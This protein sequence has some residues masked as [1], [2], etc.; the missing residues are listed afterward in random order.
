MTNKELQVVKRTGE[1]VPFN[2]TKI[3]KA[4]ILAMKNGSG[5]YL[6]DIARLISNDAEKF[7]AKQDKS[8]TIAQVEG[9]VYKRLVHYGQDLTARAYEGFRA[10]Q[11]FKREKDPLIESVMGLIDFSN[12]EVMKENANKQATLV[13]TRRDLV[14]G[15]VSKT[16]SR[17]YLI[18]P[19]LVQANDDGIIKIHDLDY[20]MDGIYNCELINLED[21]LQNGTV[22]NKKMIRK[23]KSLRTAMTIATQISAQVSSSTY[24]GQTMTL[25]HLAPFVRISKEK[26]EERFNKSLGN[27]VSQSVI[28]KLVE[29]ELRTEI[30]D[31]VQT[32]NYQINTISCT[33]GQTPFI[34]LAMYIAED[35]EYEKETAM[36]IEEFLHQRI[37][38]MENEYGVKTTQTFPKLLYFLD[39]NNTYEGSEYFYL[40]KLAAESV[41]KRM[42]PD[43]IS[44]KQ[45]EALYGTAYPCMGCRAFLTPWFNE[46]IGKY[47]CYGRGNLGVATVNLPDIALSCDADEE[48]FFE[49]LEKRLDLCKEVG[50]LRYDKL[51]G[52]KAKTA[53]ILWQ[54][55]AIARLEPEDDIIKA[56]DDRKFTVSFGYAGLHEAVLYMTGESLTSEKGQELGKKI[57]K[58]IVDYK[59]KAKAETGLWFAVYGTPSESTAGWFANKMKNRF[60]VVPGITD[61]GRITNSY[62]IDVEEEIDAFSKLEIE[63]EFAKYSLGGTITYV[64]VYNLTKNIEAVVSLVQ[65]MYEN[66]IY[67]EINTESDNC[68]T[69]GYQ[70]VI[71]V[72]EETLKWRCPQC[73]E[74]NQDKL[75]VVRRTCGYLSETNWCTSRM[76]DI[77]NRVKHL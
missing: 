53:P 41:A 51:K 42:A 45:M 8:P 1:L 15:E 37:E 21:M 5:I 68:A 66:N 69:C 36:L 23:P 52:V 64:E 43:F 77:I 10:V 40:T 25:T 13:S 65:F 9:Y 59:D 28:D 12:E 35:S 49:I 61:R 71:E 16:I 3:K 60:G 26:I 57:M 62:H 54:H 74:S 48:M 70:G 56:I 75:S 7:F 22:I 29:E 50:I 27:I 72:D 6:P 19:H 24:G 46:E 47:D 31:S 76:L 20:F 55:G 32:F 4:I 39:E 30:K 34:S 44:V 33:N 14:A 73:N 67:A 2:K 38:G 17:N 18:P 11:A 63:A 58:F